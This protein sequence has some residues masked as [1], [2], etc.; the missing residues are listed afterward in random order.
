MQVRAETV[1]LNL[2]TQ[3]TGE[4]LPVCGWHQKAC[5]LV[6]QPDNDPA[7]KPVTIPNADGLCISHYVAKYGKPPA[8]IGWRAPA[9][10]DFGPFRQHFLGARRG[11]PSASVPSSFERKR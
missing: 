2:L 3:V 6:H 7:A 11:W 4:L 9:P 8:D 5:V 10:F 1:T